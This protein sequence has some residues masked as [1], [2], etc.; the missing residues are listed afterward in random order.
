M[1]VYIDPADWWLGYYQGP[2]HHYV[3]VLPTVVIRWNRR[4]VLTDVLGDS[5]L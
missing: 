1:K 3:C 4:K 2:N 5:K